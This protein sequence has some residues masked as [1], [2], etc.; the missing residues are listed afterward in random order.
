MNE[1]F[2]IERYID[3]AKAQIKAEGPE[4]PAGSQ[5]PGPAVLH[6]DLVSWSALAD[7]ETIVS[8][9]ALGGNVIEDPDLLNIEWW[10]GALDGIGY[11]AVTVKIYWNNILLDT[12]SPVAV[13]EVFITTI[14]EMVSNQMDIT[15]FG[16]GTPRTI[17]F[18]SLTMPRWRQSGG[19]IKVTATPSVDSS[20]G[21]VVRVIRVKQ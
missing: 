1:E 6:M 3:L 4:G 21:T 17:Q 7:Q 9:Y 5:S 2:G 20:Y 13:G 16:P 15:T 14:T 10:G 19:I 18:N 8:E 11:A 12:I